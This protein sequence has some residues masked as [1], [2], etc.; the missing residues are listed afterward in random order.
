[1]PYHRP[2]G[3]TID[4]MMFF[5]SAPMA[6]QV[7]TGWRNKIM[8]AR[9]TIGGKVLIGSDGTPDRYQKPAGYSL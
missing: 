3:G 9:I 1:M 2:L 5:S 4:M 7:P 6:D 8:H